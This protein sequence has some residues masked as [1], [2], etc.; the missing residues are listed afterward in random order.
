[1]VDAGRRPLGVGRRRRLVLVVDD[2]Q[3][4]V[5]RHL[6]G[7]VV[8]EEDGE[9]PGR[10]HVHLRRGAVQS[11]GQRYKRAERGG[12]DR[13]GSQKGSELGI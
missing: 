6:D 1:M 12:Q 4:A 11:W 2:A 5:E 8:L 13:G 10:R 9:Q 7:D 3:R